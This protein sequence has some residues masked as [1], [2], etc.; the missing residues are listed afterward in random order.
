MNTKVLMK[1]MQTKWSSPIQYFIQTDEG[2]LN[3]NTLIGKHISFV[4]VDSICLSCG[5]HRD[6]FAQG[7]CKNCFFTVPEAGQ[8]IMKP[9]LCTAH[10]D[11]EDRDLKYEKEVQ[12]QDHFVYLAKTSAIKVGVTRH[13]QIPFRWIDQ[14]ADEATPILKT[15]NRYLAGKA[16]VVLKQYLTDKTSWQKMLKG[17]STSKELIDTKNE[18]KKYIPDELLAYWIEENKLTYLDFPIEK[19]PEKVKSINLSKL[20]TFEGKLEGIKG[21]YLVFEGGKVMNVRSHSG[22]VVEWKF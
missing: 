21:Q 18:I 3:I 7:F 22:Y 11:I 6:I 20:H 14:G 16:E 9:E 15:P 2:I 12:L 10:L 5:E 1:K 4:L 13:N 19:Y 17:I 8:W